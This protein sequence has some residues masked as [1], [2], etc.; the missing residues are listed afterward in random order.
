M[1]ARKVKAL[2][3]PEAIAS[4]K[5][6]IAGLFENNLN[7][8]EKA[9]QTYREVLDV[10]AASLPAMRGLERLYTQK[11]SWP[12][13]V[14]VLEQE[15]DVVTS[16]RERIDVLMKLA[17]IQEEQ[18]LK[19]DLAAARL[20]QV[21]EIDA[22][23]E[24]ALVA[25]ERCYR[26]LRQWLDLISTYERHINT[27]LDFG[28]IVFAMINSGLMQKTADDNLDDF[29]DVYDFKSAFDVGYRIESKS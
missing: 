7:D 25:L 23:H 18:F 14:G 19:A 21:L 22:S 5:L 3:E 12:E 20:E 27:T 8:P 1:L 24:P 16:E 11:S 9:A 15:L 26:R 17:T 4:H 10:D 13:L 6:R 28:R 2:K 29:R